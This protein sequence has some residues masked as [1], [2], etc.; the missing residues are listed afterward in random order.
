MKNL[1]LLFTFGN[2][3]KEW[4][5]NGSAYREI[6]YY[7][8][9]TKSFGFDKVY[10]VTYGEEDKKFAKKTPKEI[11]ILPKKYH[12]PNFIYSLILPFVYKKEIRSS[13]LVKTN[14]VLGAWSAILAKKIYCKPLFLRSGYTLSLSIYKNGNLKERVKG[15]FL[16]LA[17]RIAYSSFDLATVTTQRQKKHLLKLLN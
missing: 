5:G 3:L 11:V 1:F 14:Q 16:L 17:E 8:S 2:S 13:L 10:W 12:L 4:F 9:L 7:Q 15:L 6:D